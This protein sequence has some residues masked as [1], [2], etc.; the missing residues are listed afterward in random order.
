MRFEVTDFRFKIQVS[1]LGIFVSGFEVCGLKFQFQVLYFMF[2]VYYVL[3]VS[4]PR[5]LVVGCRCLV[6]AFR[7]QDVG[8]L[9]FCWVY[10]YILWMQCL[11]TE[12]EYLSVTEASV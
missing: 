8:W 1:V 10:V 3:L 11:S 2:W 7:F 6:L 12:K 4:G 9:S 5:F